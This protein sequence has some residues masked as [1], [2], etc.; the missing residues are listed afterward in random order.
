LISRFSWREYK[1]REIV[2]LALFLACVFRGVIL[3][4]A[5]VPL[6]I[7]LAMGIAL[8][9]FV[10]VL[11]Q[12][13]VEPA[14]HPLIPPPREIE[15]FNLGYRE[16]ASD[17]IWLRL[18]QDF[19]YCDTNLES[20][21]IT[22]IL[23]D[24]RV[25]KVMPKCSTEKG[26]VFLMLD[27]VTKLSPKFY[28]P[29][30]HGGALLSVIVHDNEGAR[31]IYERALSN[32]PNDWSLLYMAAF[33]YMSNLHDNEHAAD[34]LMRAG[35]NGAP[36]WVFGL[37]AKLYSAEGRAQF[38]KTILEQ[39]IEADPDSA[40]ADHFRARLAEIDAELKQSQAK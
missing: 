14:L 22:T 11:R 6:L 18:I 38:A 5:I 19:D 15:H 12:T 16:P 35:K 3:D 26:W 37:A 40:I 34:Y 31:L 21:I 13:G 29:Y 27:A 17:V 2:S 39:E 4:R 1:G 10:S 25:Q 36:K 9:G 20:Q 33:H 8:V 23:D 30:R 28:A 7:S 24:G 32:F